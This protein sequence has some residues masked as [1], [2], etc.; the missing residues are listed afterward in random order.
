MVYGDKGNE[1]IIGLGKFGSFELFHVFSPKMTVVED[2]YGV[3]Y[4][5]NRP[6]SGEYDCDV[7]SGKKGGLRVV[8]RTQGVRYDVRVLNIFV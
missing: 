2:G 3:L 5:G 4:G 6:E 7:A 1:I 8:D